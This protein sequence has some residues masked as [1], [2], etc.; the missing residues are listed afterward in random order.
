MRK[1]ERLF[2]LTQKDFNFQW[3]RG[4]GKGG[5]KKNKTESACICS[6][7]PSGAEGY[8]EDTRSREQNKKLAFQRL[9]ETKEFKSWLN[10]KIEA[11]CGNI[12]IEEA[13]DF[14]NI[15]NRTLRHEE[16]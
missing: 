5:Q 13:D 11:A 15:K 14:G 2:K 8:A 9:T 4:R 16:I 6:H 7:Y 12:E 1:K 10:L 3:T